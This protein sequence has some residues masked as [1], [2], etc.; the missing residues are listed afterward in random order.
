MKLARYGRD[1]PP[2]IG[3][4][5]RILCKP[6]RTC[7]GNRCDSRTSHLAES[8]RPLA[9]GPMPHRDGCAMFWSA[10]DRCTPR[11]PAGELPHPS[12]MTL[13]AVTPVIHP[14][15]VP[16]GIPQES[17]E[18]VLGVWVLRMHVYLEE[19]RHQGL[20]FE[21]VQFSPAPSG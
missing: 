17:G 7:C 19:A 10:S 13:N 6:T 18:Y 9:L 21:R 14:R 15:A 5:G 1:Y 11:P 2:M 16:T 3:D 20:C 12:K 8:S 4:R